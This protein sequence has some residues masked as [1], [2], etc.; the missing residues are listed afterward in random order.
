MH[1][2]SRLHDLWYISPRFL[3]NLV[4][5]QT[6]RVL[7]QLCR[8]VAA[9]PAVRPGKRRSRPRWGGS[10]RCRRSWRW[11][12]GRTSS[13]RWTGSCGG[14]KLF[15]ISEIRTSHLNP[16]VTSVLFTSRMFGQNLNFN[17]GRDPQKSFIWAPLMSRQT[18]V[19]YLRLYLE[20]DKKKVIRAFKS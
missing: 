7:P 4:Y 5:S 11:C 17:I 3:T 16:L 15:G 2:K 9:S 18:M 6:R 19:A 20:N 8:T 12:R 14:K 10:P 13:G 1:K